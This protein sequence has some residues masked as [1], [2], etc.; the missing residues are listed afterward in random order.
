METDTDSLYIAIARSSIDECVRPEKRQDWVRK[1]YDYFASDS[2]ELVEFDGRKISRKQ[3]E[4][5]E[6]GKYKLEFRGDGMI[7]LNSKVYH[8]WGQEGSKT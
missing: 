1:K 7:C 3:Y 8:V 4:K 6:P 5:R 2:E